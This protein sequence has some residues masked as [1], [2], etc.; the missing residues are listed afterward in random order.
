MP[1]SLSKLYV[2][3]ILS[4]PRWEPLLRPSVRGSRHAY[5]E[6]GLKNQD[7]P[8]LKIGGTSDHAHR[9]FRLSKNLA[10]ADVVEKV[11]TSSSKWLKTQARTL[12]SFYWQNG[13]GGFSVS[14]AEVDAVAAYMEGQEEQHRVVSFQDEYRRFLKE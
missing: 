7:C 3:L 13:Y 5:W 11:K 14:P 6:T 8:A 10:L 4:T 12:R 1:Q 2:H 9:L